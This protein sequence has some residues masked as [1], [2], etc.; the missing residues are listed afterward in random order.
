MIAG[1]KVIFFFPMIAGNEFRR[2]RRHKNTGIA[3]E[4]WLDPT[5]IGGDRGFL[6]KIPPTN[7]SSPKERNMSFHGGADR[8]RFQLGSA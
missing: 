3:V 6:G 5:G 7:R 1:N 2:A 4:A 8:R